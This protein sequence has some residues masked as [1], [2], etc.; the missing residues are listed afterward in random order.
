MS[1]EP[2]ASS[3]V[4]RAK[5]RA[6]E[7]AA[8][9]AARQK[10]NAA[11]LEPA[12]ESSKRELSELE[13]AFKR[14]AEAEQERFMLAT[15]SEYWVA[16]CFQSRDQKEQFLR[17]LDLIRHGDKYLDGWTVAKKLGVQLDRADVPYNTGKGDARLD[18]LT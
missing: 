3:A 17:A 9:I 10:S 6:N 16:I 8:K 18:Q 1:I 14:R 11:A 2:K 12:E 7:I 4:E 5:Q 13:A 15:D